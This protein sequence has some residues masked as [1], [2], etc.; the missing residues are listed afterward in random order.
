MFAEFDKVVRCLAL[1]LPSSVWDDVNTK[2]GKLKVEVEKFT[3]D[4]NARDEILLCARFNPQC[5]G[6][7]MV[8]V[9][10]N[11]ECIHQRKTS[12]VA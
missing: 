4:N 2:Y 7:L 11:G 6:S 1:E 3:S 5:S 9:S 12:P 8:C 10:K